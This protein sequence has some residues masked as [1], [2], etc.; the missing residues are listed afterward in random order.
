MSWSVL[1][2][3][4]S[5][6]ALG[7]STQVIFLYFQHLAKPSES[8]SELHQE[9]GEESMVAGPLVV[10]HAR[11]TSRGQEALLGHDTLEI[12]EPTSLDFLPGP[13]TVTIITF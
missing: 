5:K 6:V 7:Q 4:E 2:S 1:H 11:T 3:L 8:E 12:M 9:G 10:L 13:G